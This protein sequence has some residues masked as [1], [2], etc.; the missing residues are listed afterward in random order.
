MRHIRDSYGIT[1]FRYAGSSTPAKLMRDVAEQILAANLDVEYCSYGHVREFDPEA[2]ALLKRS[3]LF[4][5]LFGIESGSQKVLDLMNKP[6]TVEQ[7]E[8]AVKT[9]KDA[10]IF[11]VGSVILPAPGDTGKTME[12]TFALLL[13]VRPDSVFIQ[14]PG[15]YPRTPWAQ[16]PRRFGFKLDEKSYCRQVMNYKIKTLFPPSFWAP[17]PYR[18]DGMSFRRFARITERFAARLE[19]VGLVTQLTDDI[20]MVA[21]VLDVEPR[22]FKELTARAMWTGDWETIAD[23]VSSFNERSTCT[24]RGE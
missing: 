6:T 20:A 22:E 17:L 11:V 4:G 2:A 23:V 21:S 15:V 1:S 14:F 16:E 5:L 8:V 10:G 24:S 7:I 3:G 12:Q 13:D 18:L 19:K 9:A